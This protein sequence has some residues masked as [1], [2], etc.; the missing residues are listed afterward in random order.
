MRTH[1]SVLGAPAR[2]GREE[3]HLGLNAIGD[4]HELTLHSHPN[5]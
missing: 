5:S 4:E 2:S 1:G 3:Y